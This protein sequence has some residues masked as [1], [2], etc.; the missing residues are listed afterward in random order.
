MI[1]NTTFFSILNLD[2]IRDAKAQC[3][4]ALVAEREVESPIFF[5]FQGVGGKKWVSNRGC[6]FF[7][8]VFFLTATELDCYTSV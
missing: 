7:F 4:N 6:D 5:C 8:V 2:N 3:A 1:L